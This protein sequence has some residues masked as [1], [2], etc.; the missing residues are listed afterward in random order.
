MK[1][2]YQLPLFASL[3]MIGSLFLLPIVT[4]SENRIQAG[5]GISFFILAPEI[6][7]VMLIV[8]ICFIMSTVMEIPKGYLLQSITWLIL[9][10]VLFQSISN[11]LHMLSIEGSSQRLSFTSGFWVFLLGSYLYFQVIPW[12]KQRWRITTVLVLI[13]G[14]I[15]IVVL[16]NF[17]QLGLYQEYQLKVATYWKAVQQHVMLALSATVFVVGIG[18]SLGFWIYRRPQVEGAIMIVIN[19]LQ[20]IPTIALLGILMIPL[21]F[22]SKSWPF[23]AELGIKGVGWFPAFIALI[24]YGLLPMV[25]NT[26][27][28]LRNVD[29]DVL[30]A[31]KGIG[32]TKRQIFKQVNL[33]LAAPVILAGIRISVTQAMGNTILAGLIGG[34]GLGN[35]IFLG[36]AQSAPEL[37]LLGALSVVVLNLFFNFIL[38]WGKFSYDYARRRYQK[39]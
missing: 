2:L 20:V 27:A 30:E 36:L 22:I 17:S 24:C 34:G 15:T 7:G 19:I 35:F 11:E 5:E 37:I 29:A 31:A 14:L 13:L 25:V 1:R 8:S 28:G 23:L 32:M 12:P 16:A 38:E 6:S 26:V 39:I 18:I 21:T 9:V 3:L 10:F 4:I 33:P